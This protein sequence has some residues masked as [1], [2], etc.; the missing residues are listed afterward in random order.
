MGTGTSGL[1]TQ[2][3]LKMRLVLWGQIFI[4]ISI[5]LLLRNII[6]IKQHIHIDTRFNIS[7]PPLLNQ[8]NLLMSP[9]T[10]K[11]WINLQ[12]PTVPQI[13]YQ[14][15]VKKLFSII[16]QNSIAIKKTCAVVGN[17]A[18]LITSYYGK[19]IDNHDLVFRINKAPVKNYTKDVGS[20][21]S[22]RFFYPESFHEFNK[23]K[24]KL[25][26][27]PFK[28]LDLMWL[29]SV[30]TD[31]KINFTYKKVP[32]RIS[33]HKNKIFVYHPVFMKYVYD[34]WLKPHGKY[35][36]TGFLAIIFAA[37]FCETLDIYG[38]NTDS[39]FNWNHYWEINNGKNTKI[40]PRNVEASVIQSL[41]K[42]KQVQFYPGVK[43]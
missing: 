5:I 43:Q 16:P 13:V 7:M 1:K 34:N 32:A 17:S 38:F 3:S 24:M 40:H 39:M 31:G 10:F 37:H 14:T 4:I 25:I 26:I 36:S 33:S 21:T 19:M 11:W 27:V 18:N 12:G 42:N 22:Y 41:L 2:I 15:T 23:P 9:E 29:V 20:K 6:L 8:D 28:I 35:P 30:F